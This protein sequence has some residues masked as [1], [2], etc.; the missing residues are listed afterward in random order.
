[1]SRLEFFRLSRPTELVFLMSVLTKEAQPGERKV[2]QQKMKKQISSKI[3]TRVCLGAFSLVGLFLIVSVIPRA[4]GQRNAPAGACPTPWQLVASMPLDLFGAAGASDGTYSYHAGGYSFS[5]GNTLITLFRY[6]PVANTWTT[7]GPMPQAA[8]MASA[9]YYP[10]TNTIFVF[11]GEDAVSG[12][13]YNI[14]R[15]YDIASNSWSTGANMPDVRSFM[16]SGYNSVN[17]KIYLVSGYNTGF[18]D[19]AQPNTWEYD[20]VADT[21]TEPTPFP[22]PAGGFASGVINGHLYVAGGRDASNTVIDLVW[23]YDIATDTWTARSS[24]PSVTNVPGSAVALGRLWVFGGGNP[25]SA[26]K[27]SSVTAFD[28]RPGKSRSAVPTT[29]NIGVVYNPDTDIWSSTPSINVSRSFPSG[30]AIGNKLVA[31]GGYDG[32]STVSITETLDACVPITCGFQVLIVYADSGGQPSALQSQI[33]AEPGVASADLFQATAR[34]PTLAQLQLYDIIVPFSNNPFADADTLGNNLA[35]YVDGGGIV[36][37][38]AFS[39]TGPGQPNGI[40][41][42]W[43]SGNYNPYSYSTNFVFDMPFTLGTFNSGHPLMAG[44]TELNS[45]FQNVVT[46]APGATEVAAG[47]NSNSLV[48]YRPISGGHTTVGITAFLGIVANQSGHWGRVIVNAGNWLSNNG[49]APT[50][51]PTATATPTVTPTP[52]ARPTPTPRPHPTPRPRRLGG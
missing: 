39:H 38:L 52:T 28:K 23:D 48:A 26:D 25:F 37:Q 13:N 5:A 11:G 18:V 44:V 17:G 22:H 43:V 50:P 7:M 51:T 40:N 21:F 16:A 41:G 36:V 15:I 9:V 1:V 33:L 27:G 46:P 3:I 4:V 10:S 47:S 30:A 12:T 34:T 20:P 24:L 49:C 8:F 45:N 19:S 2:T 14:T 6:D 42:R 35:N 29:T 31:A 32:T